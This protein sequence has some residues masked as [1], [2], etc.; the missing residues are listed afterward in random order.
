MVVALAQR[1]T[2]SSNPPAPAAEGSN[3]NKY[4]EIFN[5]TDQ[6]VS[7][8][9][10]SLK[11][12]VDGGDWVDMVQLQWELPA[13]DAF[14]ACHPDASGHYMCWITAIEI[15][16]DGDDGLYTN[17]VMHPNVPKFSMFSVHRYTST[18]NTNRIFQRL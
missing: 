11:K 15:N 18:G 5:G 10:Y 9:N 4:I 3:N 8:E 1:H 16:F 2:I 13:G 17:K 6:T 7:L 12:G 14:Y